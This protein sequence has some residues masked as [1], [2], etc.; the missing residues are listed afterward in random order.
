[1]CN[2][3]GHAANKCASL[4]RSPLA[5]VR[6]ILACFI[7]GRRG[8]V[9]KDCRRRPT[10]EGSVGRDTDNVFRSVGRE[11]QS[12]VGVGRDTGEISRAPGKGWY[13]INRETATRSCRTTRQ[14]H[15][16]SKGFS[17]VFN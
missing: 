16:G 1:V 3:L 8:H 12:N 14:P 9:A 5:S 17:T 6:T 13:N 7:C 10:Y 2:K 15:A 11:T 4:D